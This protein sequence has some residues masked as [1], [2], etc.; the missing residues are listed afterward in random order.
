[1]RLLG[2]LVRI[3]PEEVRR[4][5]SGRRTPLL[6]LLNFKLVVK[7]PKR[8]EPSSSRGE[9][10]SP[11]VIHPVHAVL[12]ESENQFESIEGRFEHFPKSLENE[13]CINH[14]KFRN[15]NFLMMNLVIIC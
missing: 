2:N 14:K 6:S 1:M 12:D 8:N 4:R 3:P 15:W 9:S 11:T 13:K 5:I 7:Y 10:Y